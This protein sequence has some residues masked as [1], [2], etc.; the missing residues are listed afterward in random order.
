MRFLS[1]LRTVSTMVFKR[2][3]GKSHK[4]RLEGFY[5]GQAKAYDDFR[6]RLL[7]GREQLWSSV[8]IKDGMV[9]ADIGGGTGANIQNFGDNI[10]RLKKVY[11]V[12][13][14]ESLLAIADERIK[15]NG[16]TNVETVCAD[17]TTW[18]PP[19]QKVDVVSFSYSLTMIPD[20]FNAIDHATE[21]LADDG[22]VAVVDFYV[23]RK[24]PESG[25]TRHGFWTRSFWPV[26]FSCDNVFPSADH[27]PYLTHKF[28]LLS[29]EENRGRIPWHPFFWWKMPYYQLIGKKKL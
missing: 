16:W 11:I 26:W 2:V 19:E 23:S 21:I 10:K 5:S 15:A 12:D 22:L 8:P 6:R 17:A 3:R 7:K 14:S 1:D 25:R 24:Y 18:I 27:I 9:W 28:E 4:E 13:L 20:W 29:L